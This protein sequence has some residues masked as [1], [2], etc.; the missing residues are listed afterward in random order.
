MIDDFDF[1]SPFIAAS[2][3][4]VE[5]HGQLLEMVRHGFLSQESKGE[6]L[7]IVAFETFV[8]VAWSRSIHS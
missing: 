8:K 4:G 2:A 3:E 6:L 5:Y 7:T 1:R